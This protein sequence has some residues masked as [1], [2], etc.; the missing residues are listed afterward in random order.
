MGCRRG[1]EGGAL[2]FGILAEEFPALFLSFRPQFG[3]FRLGRTEFR[4]GLPHFGR[5]HPLLIQE[6]SQYL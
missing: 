3:D 4:L 6:E 2:L 5:K 1:I